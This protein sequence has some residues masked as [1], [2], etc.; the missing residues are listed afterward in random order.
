MEAAL[1]IKLPRVDGRS[2]RSRQVSADLTMVT[3]FR[4]AVSTVEKLD[5]F[6]WQHRMRKQDVVQAALDMYIEAMQEEE[7]D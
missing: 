3:S 5:E 4:L 6:C 1:P 2:L 7:T